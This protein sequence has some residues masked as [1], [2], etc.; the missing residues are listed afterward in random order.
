MIY[1]SKPHGTHGVFHS[2]RSQ[3]AYAIVR[4]IPGHGYLDDPPK[5]TILAE[6]DTPSAAY[7][8]ADEA[9]RNRIE[10]VRPPL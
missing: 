2:R 5:W 9:D 4:L 1:L 10:P 7:D 8:Y 3:G 6:R